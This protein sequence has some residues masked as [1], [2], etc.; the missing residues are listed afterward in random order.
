MIQQSRSQLRTVTMDKSSD[1]LS[2]NSKKSSFPLTSTLDFPSEVFRSIISDLS[3]ETKSLL[4]LTCRGVANT[5]GSQCLEELKLKHRSDKTEKRKFLSILEKDL[6]DHMVCQHCNVLHYIGYPTFI[7]TDLRSKIVFNLPLC[8]RS[9]GRWLPQAYRSEIP[10]IFAIALNRYRQGPEQSKYLLLKELSCSQYASERKRWGYNTY[11]K[12]CYRVIGGKICIR[13][14]IVITARSPREGT[15]RRRNHQCQICEHLCVYIYDMKS[16]YIEGL[17]ESGSNPGYDDIMT[18]LSCQT[19]F[20]LDFEDLATDVTAAFLTRWSRAR[21]HAFERGESFG[22]ESLLNGDE[23]RR[24]IDGCRP[25]RAKD[26][27][28][29]SHIVVADFILQ[30]VDQKPDLSLL[31]TANL[32]AS[33]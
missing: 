26:K 21:V 12:Y 7:G 8:A 31:L 5:I 9:T 32:L 15:T 6:R 11:S 33:G 16:K 2:D 29:L 17:Y 3:T 22:F 20:N 24:L 25:K 14:Q 13:E 28:P 10:V 1:N 19:D 23:K 4:Y 27:T 18:C 30:D